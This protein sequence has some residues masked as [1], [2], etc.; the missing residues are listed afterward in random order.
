[1]YLTQATIAANQSMQARLA[2]CAAQENATDAGVDP[3]AW[4]Y[5]WRLVWAAAPGWADAWESAEANGNPD[6]GA[7]PAV[8][9]DAQILTQ[10]QTMTPFIHIGD[11]S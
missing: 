3:Y 8:I 11:A 7:D 2:S 9:T 4:A 1:M 10:V 6:P 5:E